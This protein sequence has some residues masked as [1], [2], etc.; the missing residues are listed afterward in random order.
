[1]RIQMTATSSAIV[2]GKQVLIT[3]FRVY[4]YILKFRVNKRRG[5]LKHENNKRQDFNKRRG[6]VMHENN[7]HMGIVTLL[8]SWGHKET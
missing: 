8:I 5:F 1:M 7:Q 2:I 4:I 6:F 3:L